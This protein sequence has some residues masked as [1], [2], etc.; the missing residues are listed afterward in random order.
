MSLFR[1]FFQIYSGK[2]YQK[3]CLDNKFLTVYTVRKFL[4]NLKKCSILR[5]TNLKLNKKVCKKGTKRNIKKC[6][7]KGTNACKKIVSGVFVSPVIYNT[8][9][10]FH[11]INLA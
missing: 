9:I 3:L 7:K 10:I 6:A 5:Q 1:S 2:K 8:Q 11:K 4:K